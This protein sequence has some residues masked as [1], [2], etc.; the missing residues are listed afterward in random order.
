MPRA[1][2]RHVTPPEVDQKLALFTKIRPD[3][4]RLSGSHDRSLWRPCFRFAKVPLSHSVRRGESG[5]TRVRQV[6]SGCLDFEL[7]TRL[8]MFLWCSTPDEELL[9]P[10]ERMDDLSDDE[11]SDRTGHS[12][13]LADARLLAFFETLCASMARYAVAGVSKRRSGKPIL[14]SLPTLKEAMQ[15]EPVAFFHEDSAE[16]SQRVGLHPC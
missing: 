6:R 8:S 1:W 4:R 12:A 9:R 2:R 3:M 14:N 15:E 16:E 13:L 5:Q 7:A 11:V 10:G